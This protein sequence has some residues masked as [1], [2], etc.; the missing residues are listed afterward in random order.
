MRTLLI[1]GI[2]A[3]LAGAAATLPAEASAAGPAAASDTLRYEVR[4]GQPLLV[5]LPARH[6][7]QPASY[8]LIEGPALSWLVDRSFY[9]RTLP[10]EGGT[11]PVLIRR[12]A[13]GVEPDTLVLMVRVT[14][15]GG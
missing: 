7:R 1:L 2:V 14:P 8:R 4:A 15:A 11:M 3:A 13:P 10:T 12:V 6:G 9:W 5:A